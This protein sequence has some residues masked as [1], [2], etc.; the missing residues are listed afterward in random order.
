MEGSEEEI[1]HFP[2]LSDYVFKW[3][4]TA[5]DYDISEWEFWDMTLSE[6]ERA[7]ASK[8]RMEQRRAQERASF[9]YVLADLIGRSVGR[10]YSKDGKYPE[11]YEAYPSL[12]S[13]EEIESKKQE[14]KDEAS[15][16]RF[17]QFAAAFNSKFNKGGGKK[18]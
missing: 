11:I 9:N 13:Q 14:R 5:L 8:Q 2:L 4:N 17:R 6:L 1:S 18:E 12:F 16:L 15:A 3:L 10:I 7:I